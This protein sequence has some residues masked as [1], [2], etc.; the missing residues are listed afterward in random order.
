VGRAAE[1]SVA[2]GLGTDCSA[3]FSLSMLDAMRAA[4]AAANHRVIMGNYK[5]SL[6]NH[7]LYNKESNFI[8]NHSV[9]KK[10]STTAAGGTAAGSVA[11]ETVAAAA[12]PLKTLSFS[13]ALYLATQGSAEVLGL[14]DQIGSFEVGKQFDALQIR[15][16]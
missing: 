12:G 8:K 16:I 15:F 9:I 4:V 5:L 11:T 10:H 13:D 6:N 3:G 2:V 1:M 14:G 7:K